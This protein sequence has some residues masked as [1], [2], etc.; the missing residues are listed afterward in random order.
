MVALSPAVAPRSIMVKDVEGQ[1]VAIKNP[2][3]ISMARK[4]RS[5]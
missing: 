4:T 5:A 1:P 3:P 2:A